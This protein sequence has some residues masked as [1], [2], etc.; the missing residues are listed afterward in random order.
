MLARTEKLR[1]STDMA[2]GPHSLFRTD[3]LAE[4]LSLSQARSVISGGFRATAPWAL[5][6]WPQA[7]MKLAAV[8]D[9]ACWLSNDGT[10][11][12]LLL[13]KGDVAV[14]NDVRTVQLG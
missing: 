3:P 9:G 5:Q 8:V 11:Q 10:G 12:P 2:A 6:F 13:Q 14:L 7:R 1:E 4:A